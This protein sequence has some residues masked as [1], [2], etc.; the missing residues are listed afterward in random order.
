[1]ADEL[2]ERFLKDLDAVNAASSSTAE[3]LQK[4]E[5]IREGLA[6]SKSLTER[7]V[8]EVA[9]AAKASLATLEEVSRAVTILDELRQKSQPSIDAISQSLTNL[10]EAVRGV[11]DR[12]ATAASALDVEAVMGQLNEVVQSAKTD[13][14]RALSEVVKQL[15][16]QLEAVPGLLEKSMARTHPDATAQSL[17]RLSNEVAQLRVTTAGAVS[18]LDTASAQR[19]ID[20]VAQRADLAMPGLVAA[21]GLGLLVTDGLTGISLA[22]PLVVGFGVVGGISGTLVVTLVRRLISKLQALADE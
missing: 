15:E 16:Q 11:E 3:L 13:F 4:I 7:T 22:L 18:S 14:S 12:L 10:S 17:D 8:G 1:M 9:E 20:N 21:V 5:A 2:V 19:G 6:D